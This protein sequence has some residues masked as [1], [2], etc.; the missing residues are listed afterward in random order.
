MPICAVEA[1]QFSHQ[2]QRA[3]GLRWHLKPLELQGHISPVVAVLEEM[4][5]FLEVEQRP[6]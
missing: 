6:R 4:V 1:Q 5:F 2:G 3:S